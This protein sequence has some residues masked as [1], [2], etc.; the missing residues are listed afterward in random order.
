MAVCIAATDGG[1]RFPIPARTTSA[2]RSVVNFLAMPVAPAEI[3]ASRWPRLSGLNPKPEVECASAT[4]HV[5]N[6]QRHAWR[7]D[8][9]LAVCRVPPSFLPS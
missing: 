4:K 9:P 7:R 5:A 3:P 1:T 2:E 8:P 6:S